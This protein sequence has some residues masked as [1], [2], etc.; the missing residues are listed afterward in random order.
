M[1]PAQIKAARK[2]LGMSQAE[3]AKALGLSRSK[4]VSEWENGR[5]T[6]QPYITLAI[7]HLLDGSR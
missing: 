4:T 6:P 3:F 1:T 5:K 7:K 2:A